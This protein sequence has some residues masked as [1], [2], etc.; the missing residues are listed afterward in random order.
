MIGSTKNEIV[1]IK[2]IVMSESSNPDRMLM[3][4]FCYEFCMK[5]ILFPSLPM[6]IFD[7]NV[8]EVEIETKAY[9]YCYD[10]DW[11][12]MNGEIRKKIRNSH[13]REKGLS[14]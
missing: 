13:V 4:F 8:E 1:I 5:Y 2:N 11:P 10:C 12:I 9:Y 6:N 7:D 3:C 14:N